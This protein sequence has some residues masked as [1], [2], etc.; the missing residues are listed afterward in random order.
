MEGWYCEGMGVKNLLPVE[1]YLRTPFES[2]E[3]D[4][5][6]GELIERAMPNLFHS[7]VVGRFIHCFGRLGP[8]DLYECPELRISVGVNRFRVVDLAVYRGKP[9][10]SIPEQIPFVAIEVLSPDDRY[11]DLMLK[12]ADYAEMGIPHVWL[13]DPI[14]RRFAIYR[15]GSLIATP[16]FELTEYSFVIRLSDLFE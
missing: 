11:A 16:Q 7:L 13:V 1:E 2:P 14:S 9:S 12:F 3:P 6:D 5:V 10:G 15:D 8:R 4:Y